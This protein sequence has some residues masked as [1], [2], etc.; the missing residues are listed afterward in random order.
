MF[1]RKINLFIIR[2]TLFMLC[3]M[4][5]PLFASSG[6]S[7]KTYTICFIMPLCSRQIMDNPRHPN[8]T[9]GNACLEYYQGAL[10]ALDTFR[11]LN[12]NI[13]IRVYDTEKDSNRFRDILKKP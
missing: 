1:K 11:K 6:D 13:R 4:P 8:A 5:P 3:A 9:L 7:A 10:M 2:L 12:I